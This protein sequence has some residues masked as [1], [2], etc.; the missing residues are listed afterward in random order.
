MDFTLFKYLKE[1]RSPHDA[2]KQAKDV[3]ASI[4]LNEMGG[5]AIDMDTIC[6]K[7]L[8][9][10]VYKYSFFGGMEPASVLY[11]SPNIN[12]GTIAAAPKHPFV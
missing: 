3:F 6:V 8:D 11:N 4:V 12:G 10:L 1:N 5:V 9:E 2:Y 7:P